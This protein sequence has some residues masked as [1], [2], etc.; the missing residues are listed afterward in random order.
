MTSDVNIQPPRATVDD[1]P[2]GF[3]SDI[4][5]R[6]AVRDL[7]ADFFA[8][9]PKQQESIFL[10]KTKEV[11]MAPIGA[12][13]AI[14]REAK[15]IVDISRASFGVGKAQH[16]LSH[17]YFKQLHDGDDDATKA[18]IASLEKE[19]AKDVPAEGLIDNMFRASSAQIPQLLEIIEKGGLGAGIGAGVGAAGALVLGQIGPQAFLPEELF[20]VPAAAAGG[21]RIGGGIGAGNVIFNT[22]AGN[23]FKELRDIKGTDGKPIDPKVAKIGAYVAGL[24]IA[25]LEAIPLTKMAKLVPGSDLIFKKAGAKAG[26]VLKL[27]FNKSSSP[28]AK[29]DAIRQF[30]KNLAIVEAA[31]VTTEVAQE[32]VQIATNEI[33]K[34]ISDGDFDHIKGEEIIDRLVEAGKEAALAT[35]GIAAG[36]A[37]PRAV[38][39]IRKANKAAKAAKGQKIEGEFF[40]PVQEVVDAANAQIENIDVAIQE[41]TNPQVVENLE[42]DKVVVTEGVSEVFNTIQ[43]Q[44]KA[45]KPEA[46]PAIALDIAEAGFKAVKKLSIREDVKRVQTET[47]K[48]L[49]E[50]NLPKEDKGKFLA[51][52]KNIQTQAQLQKRL[53][54]LERRVTNLL[55]KRIRRDVIKGVNKALKGTK[56][57]VERKIRKSKFADPIV[58]ERFDSLRGLTK[59]TKAEAGQALDAKLLEEQETGAV[60]PIANTILALKADRDS[61][62][63]R[64][65]QQLLIDIQ[66]TVKEGKAVGKIKKA[67]QRSQRDEIAVDAANSIIDVAAIDLVD[68]TTYSNS[69][70][71]AA[72][73][74]KGFQE[75]FIYGWDDILDITF[76]LK[77]VDNT[78]IIEALRVTDQFQKRKGIARRWQNSFTDKAVAALGFDKQS[79]YVKKVRNDHKLVTVGRFVNARNENVLFQ[80][81]KAQI[82]QLWMI[83]QDESISNTLTDEK[84]NAFTDEMITA[85]TDL[86]KTEDIRLAQ[87]RLDF[88]RNSYE[89]VNDKFSEVNGVNLPFNE[90]YSPIRREVEGK[91]QDFL[92]FLKAENV[93]GFFQEQQYRASVNK[94]S[95]KERTANILP[96][97][98][99]GDEMI[100]Q[101]HMSEMSH[102]VAFADKIQEIAQ[103]TRNPTLRKAI[104]GKKGKLALQVMDTAVSDFTRGYVREATLL[105][106]FI[107]K[108]NSNFARSVLSL[109]P[110]IGV[111]QLSSIPAYA[112]FVTIPEFIDGTFEFLTNPKKVFDTLKDSELL[113]ERGA[114][115]E[116]Q[117]ADIA[118]TDAAK[119]FRKSQSVD[120]FLG[121]FIELGDKGAIVAGG[122]S[123]YKAARKKGLTH[124]QAITEFERATAAR[125]QSADLDKLSGLQRSGALGRLFSQF[126][127]APNA[128]LRA[129]MEAIRQ[130]SR[131]KITAR[132]FGKRMAIY[133]LLLPSLFQF[134]A[135]GFRY[136]E[137]K[138]AV[139]MILGAMNGYFILGDLLKQGISR[140]VGTDSFRA[141][142][143]NFYSALNEATEGAVE[144]LDAVLDNDMEDFFEAMGEVAQAAGKLTGQPIE[145]GFNV[146]EGAKELAEGEDTKKGALLI[147]GWPPGAIKD[148][149]GR[150]KTKANGVNL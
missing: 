4:P 122:W 45:A 130:F 87:E 41:E 86:L 3:F 124:E 117:I 7:P 140:A 119:Q 146:Y 105:G 89:E 37:T 11:I 13:K 69:L 58:Q 21:A 88:Y 16:Q 148:V 104:K 110:A 20:T 64:E 97:K 118:N 18:K 150:K 79:Q 93:D 70:S 100:M 19:A 112:E 68:Q 71:E 54:E 77:G 60:D 149:G 8:D 83:T 66:D 61:V 109:K 48:L 134:I 123:V 9:A 128:Y 141:K 34:L 35:P 33:S 14:G 1:L 43:E 138:Q 28:A 15:E 137:D 96:I 120:R 47:I 85:A 103:I 56:A 10:A 32:A 95:L 127:S 84:G 39:D 67:V 144:A 76:N 62:P 40:G 49:N 98:L 23:A 5:A 27:P 133:H 131:G 24:S 81:N 72:K 94:G 101:R 6:G 29:S 42:Q 25:G 78:Q 111:K 142:G 17:L 55:N 82:R 99:E 143:I 125:Q 26:S 132:D 75:F 65:A 114:N 12:A 116:K 51:T 90:N 44:A 74:V 73:S 126:L 50:L 121:L 147:L 22:S 115:P 145:Q 107:N 38:I 135:D 129:E 57:K 52:V 80:L 46:K 36:F 102:Y 53:P 91:Q 30:A 136:E 63:A 59:L 113:A 106:R 92:A 108:I 31:E 139:A 2:P